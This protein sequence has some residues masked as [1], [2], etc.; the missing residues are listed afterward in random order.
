MILLLGV[1]GL[2]GSGVYHDGQRR[3]VLLLKLDAIAPL[4]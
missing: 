1:A 2:L 3:L 4:M